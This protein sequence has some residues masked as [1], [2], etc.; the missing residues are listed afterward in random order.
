MP[1]DSKEEFFILSV[2]RTADSPA[3]VWWRPDA[4]GYT[5]SIG[6]AGRYSREEAMRHSDPPHH[7]VIPC[8]AV[9]VP[10]A[11]AKSFAKKALSASRWD[12][13]CQWCGRTAD[14]VAVNGHAQTCDANRARAR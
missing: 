2:E 1:N 14:Q 12:R 10:A 6:E 8:N 11:R 3:C 4:C 9:E 7:L 5:T 13:Q